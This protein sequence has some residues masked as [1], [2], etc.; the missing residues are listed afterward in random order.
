MR[1]GGDFLGTF[2]SFFSKTFRLCTMYPPKENMN[3]GE[4][5]PHVVAVVSTSYLFVLR[6][7]LEA[8]DRVSV[9]RGGWRQGGTQD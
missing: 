1:D 9:A 2:S 7:M 6:L 8:L 4:G 3:N 5:G